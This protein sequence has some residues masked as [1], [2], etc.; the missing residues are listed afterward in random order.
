MIDLHAHLLPG[1][2]DGA[3]DLDQAVEMCY[4]AAA[5]GCS[6]M[7]ATPHQRHPRWL[8]TDRAMLE[9]LLLELRARVG[10]VPQL[11]LGAEIRIGKGLVDDLHDVVGT[12][13]CP[14]ADSSYLLLEFPRR[15]MTIDP[16]QTILSVRRAGWRPIVAHPEFVPGLSDDPSIAEDLVEAGALLQLTAMSVTGDFG[17]RAQS[18]VQDLIER[19]LAHFIS[20]DSHDTDWRRPGLRR[21]WLAVASRWGEEVAVR[22]TTDNPSAVIENQDIEPLPAS[23]VVSNLPTT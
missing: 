22:L 15:R 11:F 8:N 14:L 5:A 16:C 13:L 10:P 4:Q 20:S 3:F 2:D 9:Q 17:D 6:A 21:A 19:D 12:G 1:I 23:C 7:V 18:C